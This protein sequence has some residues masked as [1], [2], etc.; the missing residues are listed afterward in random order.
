MNKEDFKTAFDKSLSYDFDFLDNMPPHNF[1]SQ[2]NKKINKIIGNAN[3][4]NCFFNI[5]VSKKFLAAVASFFIL[6]ICAMRVNAISEPVINFINNICEK[7]NLITFNNHSNIN[8][9]TCE[10]SL[11]YIPDNFTIS[12]YLKLDFIIYSKY[13]N[14]NGDIIDISQE[15]IDENHERYLDN[16]NG[17]IEIKNISGMDILWYQSDFCI[18]ALWVQDNYDMMLSCTAA[19]PDAEIIKMIE[20]VKAV[21][22]GTSSSSASTT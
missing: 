7:Y 16:E 5:L 13:T 4:K 6:L 19:L 18:I 3:K 20:S 11:T 2:T 12:D 10:Y 1:S 17:T 15:I 22:N 21:D 9:I 14:E 8:H